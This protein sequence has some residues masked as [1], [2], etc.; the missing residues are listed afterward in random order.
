MANTI[1]TF[2]GDGMVNFFP[3]TDEFLVF[4]CNCSKNLVFQCL[5]SV[6]FSRDLS[7][8][9]NGF[10]MVIPAQNHHNKI[11]FNR[12]TIDYNGFSM[13][14]NGF[15]ESLHSKRYLLTFY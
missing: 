12:L 5:F 10:P 13:D 4:S 1:F 14:W 3:M 2:Q 11:F 7:I 6:F 15:N 8:G 9:M